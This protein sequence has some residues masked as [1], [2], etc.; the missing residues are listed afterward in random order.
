MKLA[1]TG[2][3]GNMG[4]AVMKQLCSLEN[5][6]KIKLLSR[7]RKRIKK[8]LK[9]IKPLKDKIEVI[10]GSSADPE[11]CKK[12]VDGVDYVVNMGAVIPPVAD[13]NPRAAVAANEV[14]A[15]VL[16]DA[17]EN[18]TENQPKFI[19]ISTMA[20]YGNRNHRH[21]WGRVGDPLLV[22][23]FDVYAATKLRGEFKVLESKIKK[24]AV[25]RQTAMLH[26]NML[27]DNMSD[28]LMFH[29]C[30]NA[31]LEWATAHDSGVLIKN[32]LK[33]DSECDLGD[34]FWKKCFNLGGGEVNR[35]TGFDTLNDGFKIIG[36]SAK[37]F[38]DPTYNA[39]RNFHGLWFS[40]GEVLN[41]MF[42]YISQS[43]DDYWKRIAKLHPVYALGKIVPK[44]I[45]RSAAIKRL[46]KN[47]NSPAYWA[48]HG[49]EE[50]LFA[51]FGGRDKYES[52]PK[53][54]SD[55]DLLAEGRAEGE[56]VDYEKLKSEP[57]EIDYGFDFFK[58]D[59]EIT[60]ADLEAVATAH[61]G[62]LVSDEFQTGDMY[63]TL[64]WQTQDGEVFEA[65]AYT[66]LRAGHWYNPIYKEYVWDFDRL[67]K[68]DKIWAQIWYD[69]HERDENRIYRLDSEFNVVAEK[70]DDAR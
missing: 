56:A 61:G 53:K 12:L 15:A 19:H 68:K 10:I 23:P 27:S 37:D 39:T 35:L 14:G 60:K 42:D 33:K 4:Q 54:W 21:P 45:I 59:G 38:F 52:L 48:K 8:L 17:V 18:I 5:I 70:G 55:F 66:V 24:W 26:E 6:E 3:T 7:N 57:T 43:T 25:I 28:G 36:G 69:S 11:V 40:D 2:S 65:N 64:Q 30:F 22:S 46:F 13:I 51:Y 34:K 41:D 32:M 50:R 9:A 47:Y 29:T 1:I 62:K 67:A 20:L 49:D 31:P 16:V 44:G 58:S 63:K